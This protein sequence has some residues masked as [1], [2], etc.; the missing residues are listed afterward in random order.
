[1]QAHAL[2]PEGALYDALI[3]VMEAV[4]AVA[5]PV[6]PHL[7]QA[8]LQSLGLLPEPFMAFVKDKGCL[9]RWAQQGSALMALLRER[10]VVEQFVNGG[11]ADGLEGIS[12]SIGNTSCLTGE[13]LGQ[14]MRQYMQS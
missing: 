2:L 8:A 13:P 1:M 7:L 4:A 5:G 11:D 3:T 14:V 6:Q 12:I 10:D 9:A